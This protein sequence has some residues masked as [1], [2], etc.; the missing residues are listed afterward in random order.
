MAEATSAADVLGKTRQMLDTTQLGLNDL[1][2]WDASRRP[3]GLL[4]VATFGRSVTLVLQN[5]RTIDRAG[6]DAWYA[7][8]LKEMADDP[9]LQYFKN[10][11]NEI[12]KEGPPQMGTRGMS[13]GHFDSDMMREYEKHMPPGAE[14]FFVGDAW[15]GTGWAVSLPDGTHQPYYV[16]PL[17]GM[18]LKTWV[19]MPN[20]PTEHLGKP[21]PDQDVVTLCTAYVEYLTRVVEAAEAHFGS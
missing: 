8:Y 18:G 4:N 20:A 12:L 15:G 13:L 7:P 21:L 9:L 1:K 17:E 2:T 14:G 5:M 19:N 3:T 11:R 10:L 6:F 16:E